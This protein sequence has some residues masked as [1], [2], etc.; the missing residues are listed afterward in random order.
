MFQATGE[1]C[2][3]EA[4]RAWFERTLTMRRP[5]QG[6]GGY[7]AWKTDAAGSPAWSADPSLL[8]G[9][10]GIAL[11]LLAAT[12]PIEPLWDRMLLVSTPPRVPTEVVRSGRLPPRRGDGP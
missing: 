12:S 6:I 7:E 8:N 3:A 11:A 4:A 1:P 10:T 9:S 2:L 5:G